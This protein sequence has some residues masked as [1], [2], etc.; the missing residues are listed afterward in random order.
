MSTIS[1]EKRNNA[2]NTDKIQI[3]IKTIFKSLCFI[4]KKNLKEMNEYTYMFMH[5]PTK[6]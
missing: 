6:S 5:I 1:N 2:T 3:I 4:V